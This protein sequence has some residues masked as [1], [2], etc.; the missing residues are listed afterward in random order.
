MIDRASGKTGFCGVSDK[1]KIARAALHY[2]EEPCISGENGSGAVFFSGC[3]LHCIFCQNQA[4]SDGVRGKE[5]TTERLV[6]IFFELKAKGANNINLVTPSHYIPQIKE[7]IINAKKLGFDLPFVYNSSGYESIASLQ[8]L[9]GLIDIYLPDFKYMS[10][11][12][13]ENFSGAKNYPDV[14]KKTI[15][16]MHKQTGECDFFDNGI[17]KKG[18]IVRHLLL[19]S[20]TRDSMA[21]IDYLY[22]TYGDN[23]FL[24]LMSQYT[25]LRE[26]HYPELNRRLTTREYNRVIDHALEIGVKNAYIQEGDVALKSFIP[27]FNLEGV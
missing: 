23:I 10:Y 9:D 2:W 4:I 27:D 15:E 5:I 6:G 24:S 18:V 26:L 1:L 22:A 3:N 25:P 7:S 17:I 14:V 13:A 21:V 16:E 20:H 11:E 8:K 12:L 19:P